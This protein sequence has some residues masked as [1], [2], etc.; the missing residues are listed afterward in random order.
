MVSQRL[1]SCFLRGGFSSPLLGQPFGYKTDKKAPFKKNRETFASGNVF[2]RFFLK[3]WVNIPKSW[4]H[5]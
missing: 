3:K 4:A 5:D 1:G 2:A